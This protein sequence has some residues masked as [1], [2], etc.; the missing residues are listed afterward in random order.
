M[1]HRSI[2]FGLTLA[3][4][5]PPSTTQ[6]EGKAAPRAVEPTPEPAA[7]LESG[8]SEIWTSFEGGRC[9]FELREDEEAGGLLLDDL[10]AEVPGSPAGEA[11]EACRDRTCVY[12][13]IATVAGPLV[14]AVAPS[15]DSGMPSGV[16]LGYVAEGR[17]VF[18]DLWEDAGDPVQTDYTR[19]G[20]AH[21][22]APFVCEDKLAVLAVPRLEAARGLEPPQRLQAREGR[23]DA[24]GSSTALA[25]E[26]RAGCEAV[27][28][29]V[30]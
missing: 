22:L 16:F 17:L 4:C 6:E 8:A 2:A 20:P 18:V 10:S 23:L 5:S 26:A 25:P 12:E 21:A 30:P 27:A 19:V 7:C 13:G 15:S 29:P 3:A 11:P 28:L 1:R 9:G 24:A 14:L